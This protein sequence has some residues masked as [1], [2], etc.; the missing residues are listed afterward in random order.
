MNTSEGYESL[1]EEEKRFLKNIAQDIAMQVSTDGKHLAAA[2]KMR[3]F[4]GKQTAFAEK[5]EAHNTAREAFD[6]DKWLPSMGKPIN[7]LGAIW[8]YVYGCRWEDA[9]GGRSSAEGHFFLAVPKG[10]TLLG[11]YTL[12]GVIHDK[13]LPH[14]PCIAKGILPVKLVELI[15]QNLISG[16]DIESKTYTP[17]NGYS[18]SPLFRKDN[19]K[20]ALDNVVADIEL[21]SR[22][23]EAASAS[24]LGSVGIA[25]PKTK[26]SV[27]TDRKQ[28]ASEEVQK[29]SDESEPQEKDAQL[30][31]R[32]DGGKAGDKEQTTPETDIM[33]VKNDRRIEL[34]DDFCNWTDKLINYIKHPDK[35]REVSKAKVDML[36]EQVNDLAQKIWPQIKLDET[37]WPYESSDIPEC[38]D[39]C[40][41][42]VLSIQSELRERIID[43]LQQWKER[44]LE[45]K[46]NLQRKLNQQREPETQ[47][48][49]V[50][51]EDGR[52]ETDTAGYKASK[53]SKVPVPK[54]IKCG[55]SQTVEFKE[56]LEYDV[57]QN[58]HNPNLN[59]ECLRTIAAFLNTDGGTLLI[60]IKDNG[61]V[62]GIERD[63]EDVQRKNQ[64]GFEL[65]LRN[66]IRSRFAPPPLGK[67]KIDFEKL[68]RQT[69]CRI[70]VSP[71]NLNQISHLDSEV[72]IRDGNMTVKLTGRDLTE[73]IQQRSQAGNT[74][75]E[76]ENSQT[77][78][79][80]GL[81]PDI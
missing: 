77:P 18:P 72:Y 37:G 56:T 24:G 46:S 55:E 29:A 63:L 23:T 67:V 4:R 79:G 32:I 68:E 76:N 75:A 47:Q 17:G 58:Q 64:D 74:P 13:V 36:G 57:K 49:G 38:A 8:P 39:L 61:E 53:L 78:K 12:L 40:E 26:D 80:W 7:P 59:K 41:G 42:S 1:S 48:V 62:T 45:D 9:I 25:L 65:K 43:R 69:V 44:A 31:T 66:L 70:D 34:I 16:I 3:H 22:Q 11:D 10:M 2:E 35:T 19:I 28:K 20:R 30:K 51:E 54:L 15:W 81:R 5:W 6:K 60:G 27:P 52:T 33:T 14:C 71:L 73:W 50:Q 21:L